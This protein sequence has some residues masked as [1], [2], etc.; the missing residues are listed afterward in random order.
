MVGTFSPWTFQIVRM[1]PLKSVAGLTGGEE[2]MRNR[3][4]GGGGVRA[5]IGAVCALWLIRS[6]AFRGDRVE[7]REITMR[8]VVIGVF[9][10]D[11]TAD[12][13]RAMGA[14]HCAPYLIPSLPLRHVT[15]SCTCPTLT[16]FRLRWRP[17]CRLSPGGS[18]LTKPS[19]QP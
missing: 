8:E 6:R 5:E 14:W 7:R 18:L 15:T 13:T 16:S 3:V 9:G 1:G 2:L 4:S 10:T 12:L 19:L 17:G 11:H